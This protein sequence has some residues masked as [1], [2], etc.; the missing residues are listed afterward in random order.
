MLAKRVIINAG[1]G[2][3]DPG[4]VARGRSE[5]AEAI[6]ITNRL[7]KL[8]KDDGRLQVVQVPNGLGFLDGIGW[9]N[10]RYK[11]VD[12]AVAISIHKNSFAGKAYGVELWAGETAESQRMAK[13]LYQF[14]PKTTG[15][16][17]RGVK[18]HK[19]RYSAGL[20]WIRDVNTWSFLH[21]CGFMQTDHFANDKYAKGIFLG[22]LNLY[23]M[24]EKVP[25]KPAPK[26]TPKPTPKPPVSYYRVFDSKGKQTGAFSRRE[27]AW[28][29]FLL[30]SSRGKVTGLDGSDITNILREENLPKAPVPDIDYDHLKDEQ[31]KLGMR[32]TKIEGTLAKIIKF[33][34]GL[35][36]KD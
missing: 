31:A 18:N 25:P 7:Y 26:P 29:A 28:E 34:K 5:A 15:L 14:M 21:E 17:D 22:I 9:V 8:L 24:K 32:V 30:Q 16:V 23:G 11:K 1:H 13:K 4:A 33:L 35:L 2:N 19:T 27:G 10:A 3:G 6:D 12:D 20:A 36:W